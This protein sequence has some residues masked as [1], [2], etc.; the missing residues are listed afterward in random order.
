MF[1]PDMKCMG[2]YLAIFM[3]LFDPFKYNFGF[4]YTGITSS[5][6]IYE[7]FID[8]CLSHCWMLVY[9]AIDCPCHILV[10]WPDES[11]PF[12]ILRF[13]SG[14][15]S[16]RC[17]ILVIGNKCRHACIRIHF[18]WNLSVFRKTIWNVH[19]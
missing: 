8:R 10:T 12:D 11:M 5:W 1:G 2:S 14:L 9:S 13:I 3:L 18:S 17:V 15:L 4:C 6:S 19:L 16:L 7:I